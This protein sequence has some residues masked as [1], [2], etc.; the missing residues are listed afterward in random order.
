[1][2]PGYASL[3]FKVDDVLVFP[4]TAGLGS[5][6]RVLAAL[7]DTAHDVVPSPVYDDDF[8]SSLRRQSCRR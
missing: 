2:P 3:V 1:M 6:T 4:F 8:I 5:V 7:P